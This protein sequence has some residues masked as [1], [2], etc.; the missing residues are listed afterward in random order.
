M[1]NHYIIHNHDNATVVIHQTDHGG[2]EL[3]IKV[4]Q[5]LF[6]LIFLLISSPVT[7]PLILAEMRRDRLD[8]QQRALLEGGE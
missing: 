1:N 2:Q 4:I 8:A 6:G 3:A 5:A 7:V